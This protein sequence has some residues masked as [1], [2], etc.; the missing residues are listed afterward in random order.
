MPGLMELLDAL[1]K[2]GI[3]KAIGTS[4]CRELVAACLTPFDMQRRFESF[5][6]PR[7]SSTAN[8]TPRSIW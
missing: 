6:P 8:R 1:E 7:T 4:S 2:A 3:P 5:L